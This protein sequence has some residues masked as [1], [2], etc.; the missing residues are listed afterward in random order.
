M[1]M[2]GV[3]SD[4][5]LKAGL[6]RTN[7]FN[8]MPGI[9]RKSLS[10]GPEGRPRGKK[11][12]KA[13][14]I[15][16]ADEQLGAD[17]EAGDLFMN[18][19]GEKNT[20]QDD[21]DEMEAE[22]EARE[23]VEEKRLRLARDFLNHMEN[24]MAR[25]D[26]MRGVTGK[27]SEDEDEGEEEDVRDKLGKRL[28]K[29]A[30]EASGRVQKMLAHRLIL[31]SHPEE[32]QLCGSPSSSS[33]LAASSAASKK[34]HRLP[35]T[36]IALSSTDSFAIS[37]SKDGSIIRWDLDTMKRTRMMRPGEESL[38]GKRKG[39]Q[40][41][42]E[43]ATGADWVKRNPRQSS[44]R[45]LYAVAISS[46][47]KFIAV[48]GGDKKIYLFDGPSGS[49]L[50]SFPGHRD[51]ITGLVFRENTH[52]LYSSSSDRTV[53]LWSIDDRAYVDTLF[54]HQAEILSLDILRTERALSGGNDRTVRIWK[55]P[56][57]SQLVFRAPALS[58]DCVK[59]LSQSEFISGG[60]D[61]TLQVWNQLRKKPMSV[62][63]H[64]HGV[65]AREGYGGPS[66]GCA[67]LPPAPLDQ[68]GGGPSMQDAVGWIQSLA[69]CNNSD[70]VASGASDGTIRL[71][72]VAKN[73]MQGAQELEAIGGLPIRG[74]INGLAW[75]RKG[76][77]LVAAVGQEP[78]MGRWVR[79][80]KAQNGIAVFRLELKP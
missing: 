42:Q 75:S 36:A 10:K 48:G 49:F 71:W 64:A 3:K 11:S 77:M 76:T 12:E 53:K 67:I 15:S 65:G 27:D 43:E 5:G 70:L 4:G 60:S 8:R 51:A 28:K 25:E 78:R 20:A 30:L 26:D 69:V 23:S 16:R 59:L 34:G 6:A 17:E 50:Q 38:K 19:Q 29:D 61:S 63:S 40:R 45:G 73:K 33:A 80:S 62:I 13:P 47:D 9:K 79:D 66:A 37:V 54:G 55:I 31:P 44:K 14:P 35:A 74:C 72:R 56:E 57:E 18:E 46:D 24:E 22:I 68:S 39:P 1:G 21:F 58:T 2:V 41:A 52:Q 32:S 7:V